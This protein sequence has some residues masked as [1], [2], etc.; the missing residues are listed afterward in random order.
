MPILQTF[1][2]AFNLTAITTESTLL[3]MW[4]FCAGVHKDAYKQA[5]ILSVNKYK[6]AEG[7]KHW[8]SIWQIQY[9]QNLHTVLTDSSKKYN[10]NNAPQT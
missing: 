2:V 1:Y 6:R 5:W 8:G 10:D 3:D 9:S 7:D 4:N